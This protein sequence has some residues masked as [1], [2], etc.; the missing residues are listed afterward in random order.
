MKLKNKKAFTR[1]ELLVVIAIIAILATLAIVALQQARKS[2]RDAKRIADIRQMQTALELYFNDWGQY[3]DSLGTS[4]ASGSY[5]YMNQVP[6]APTPADNNCENAS[7]TYTYATTSSGGYVNSYSISFCLGG[8]V[9]SLPLGGQTAT[10][11]GI[12]SDGDDGGGGGTPAPVWACEDDLAY[13]GYDY[14]T[15]E[16]G[17][18]CWFAENLKY[19]NGCSMISYGDGGWCGYYNYDGPLNSDYGLLYQWNAAMNGETTEGAQGV[20]PTGWH[21]PTDA[22]WT[23]LTDWLGNNGHSGAEGTALKATSGNIPAWNGTDDFGFTALPAGELQNTGDFSTL[24]SVANFWSSSE[25]SGAFWIR[26]LLS[27]SSE[28]GIG[29]NWPSYGYSLRCLKD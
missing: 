4:I 11:G 28:F 25:D 12:F 23:V 21:V 9:G 27:G 16:I 6:T 29:N 26:Y 5:I 7:N 20:C 14:A 1:V 13:Q 2:A 18:Q 8:Q 19:D 24:T 17:T 15:V 22:Q 3:P 10:P